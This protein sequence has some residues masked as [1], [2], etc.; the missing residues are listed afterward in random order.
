MFRCVMPFQLVQDTPRFLWRERLVQ[1]PHR[2]GVEIVRHQHDLLGCGEVLVYQLLQ[3][4]SEVHSR[5]P[6]GNCY[7]AP[8]RQRLTQ[9]EDVGHPSSLVLVVLSAITRHLLIW[10]RSWWEWCS[11]WWLSAQFLALLVHAHLRVVRI[12]WSMEHLQHILHLG[13]ELGCGGGI[14][15]V[16][17]RYAPILHRPRTKPVFL[18][19][20]CTPMLV[21]VS[22]YPSSTILSASSR[23]V[24]RSL[25]WGGAEQAS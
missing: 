17:H 3:L 25:P 5:T 18:S 9:H 12:V 7:P 4:V 15:V 21:M 13:Y 16:P 14:R 2:M 8:P 1:G 10:A 6:L 20:L 19:R 11:A 22:M 24:Q 23:S